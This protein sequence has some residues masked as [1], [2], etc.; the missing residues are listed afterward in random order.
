MGGGTGRPNTSRPLRGFQSQGACG[1]SPRLASALTGAR[2]SCPSRGGA[3]LGALALSRGAAGV[4]GRPEPI[5]TLGRSTPDEGRPK[6]AP[7][8]GA[9]GVSPKTEV[10][11]F[12]STTLAEVGLVGSRGERS[13]ARTV[14][15]QPRRLF[16]EVSAGIESPKRD[17]VRLRGRG[18]TDSVLFGS[19]KC[20]RTP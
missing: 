10:K 20:Q 13:V 5:S 4:G 1:H 14:Q 3:T 16:I 19:R 2:Q 8:R 11:G 6:E 15:A 9:L 7:C 12:A 17:E 18:R